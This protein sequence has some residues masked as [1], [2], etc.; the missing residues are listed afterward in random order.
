MFWLRDVKEEE[1]FHVTILI[2]N[3]YIFV[4]YRFADPSGP[5]LFFSLPFLGK[6]ACDHRKLTV[7]SDLMSTETDV[8]TEGGTG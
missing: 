6:L 4:S 5:F 1:G 3:I 2:K 8:E 7:L